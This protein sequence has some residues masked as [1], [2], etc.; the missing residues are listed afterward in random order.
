M[1][2]RWVPVAVL[3]CLVACGGGGG[4]PTSP[5]STTGTKIIGVSGNLAF[6]HVTVGTTA[7]ATFT[8]SN[9][10]TATLTVTGMTVTGGLSSVSAAT[11]TSGTIA[12]GGT[13]L[14]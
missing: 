11:W 10:G 3:A 9:S 12:A 2:R 8:I 7:P 5:G 13:Q 4:S 6:G 1:V 14:V